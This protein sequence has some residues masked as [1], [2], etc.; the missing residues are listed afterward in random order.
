MQAFYRRAAAA[1]AARV[2][3]VSA[4]TREQAASLAS[5]LLA[6]LPAAGPKACAE[7][8]A[9]DEVP[10]LAKSVLPPQ[11]CQPSTGTVLIGRF[12]KKSID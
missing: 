12:L 3:M 10:P 8:P 6:H 11:R 1:C 5:A 9:I 2:S 4:I 7:Q